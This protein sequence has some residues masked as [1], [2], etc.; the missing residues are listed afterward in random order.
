MGVNH[1]D[2]FKSL[3]SKRADELLFSARAPVSQM[4]EELVTRQEGLV[5]GVPKGIDVNKPPNKFCDAMSRKDRQE[6]AEAYD[7]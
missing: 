5:T 6:W 3:L 2:F 4:K 7:S 1:E